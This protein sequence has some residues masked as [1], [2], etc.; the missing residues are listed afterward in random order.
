[1]NKHAELK[2]LGS[3]DERAWSGEGAAERSTSGIPSLVLS[4]LA[5]KA[6]I[7]LL[8]VII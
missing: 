2:I 6:G 1:M 7:G 5:V 8:Q 3:H 4:T